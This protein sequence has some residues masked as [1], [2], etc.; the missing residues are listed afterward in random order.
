MDSIFKYANGFL[1]GLFGLL[2]AVLPVSILWTIMTGG[3]L[4][5]LN[6]I[7]GLTSIIDSFGNGGFTGLI[8]M[9]IVMSFFV[10]K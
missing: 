7:D 10:K 2:M 8:V 9:V 1:T 4:F 6:V 3:S 5:G